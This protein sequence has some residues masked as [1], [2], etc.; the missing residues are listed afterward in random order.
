M[1]A[2]VLALILAILC[3]L[4]AAKPPTGVPVRFEWLGAAFVVI[5]WLF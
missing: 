3:F 4:I 2:H 5:A 1:T